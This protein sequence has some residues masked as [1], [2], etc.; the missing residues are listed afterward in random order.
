M[1]EDSLEK[2]VCG[3]ISYFRRVKLQYSL[4]MNSDFN[5]DTGV[6]MEAET[7]HNRLSPRL[8]LTFAM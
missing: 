6:N 5:E 4:Y 7:P 2:G 8:L 1:N 3:E